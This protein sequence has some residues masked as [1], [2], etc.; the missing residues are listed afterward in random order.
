MYQQPGSPSHLLLSQQAHLRPPLSQAPQYRHKRQDQQYHRPPLR[1]Q[2]KRGGQGGY[3]LRCLRY[4]YLCSSALLSAH[5]SS[6]HVAYLRLNPQ[7][8]DMHSL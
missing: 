8:W 3:I 7:S 1:R 6:T 5:T 4:C 2:Y